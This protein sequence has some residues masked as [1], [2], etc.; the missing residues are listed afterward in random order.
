MT[1][2]SVS[3]VANCLRSNPAL[4][5][6]APSMEETFSPLYQQTMT[7]TTIELEN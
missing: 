7:A 4:T 3:A 6:L 5:V 2:A 1:E